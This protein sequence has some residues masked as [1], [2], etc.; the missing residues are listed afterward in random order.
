[1]PDRPELFEGL[2]D[3]RLGKQYKQICKLLNV[4]HGDMQVRTDTH[5]TKQIELKDVF[6]EDRRYL[7]EDGK[8]FFKLFQESKKDEVGP[9]L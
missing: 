6:E 5:T 1:M 9:R 4:G 3:E 7:D 2:S 8:L